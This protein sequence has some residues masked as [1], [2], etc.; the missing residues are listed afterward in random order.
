VQVTSQHGRQARRLRSAT[1]APPAART[2]TTT[3]GATQPGRPVPPWAALRTGS[4]PV[5]ADGVGSDAVGPDG[6]TLAATFGEDVRAA[7]AL[8]D[9]LGEALGEV[10]G[11]TPADV[12]GDDVP[13]TLGLAAADALPAE[14]LPIGA[15]DGRGFVVLVVEEP[16]GAGWLTGAAGVLAAVGADTP[17]NDLPLPLCQAQ[18]TAP[19]SGT[20]SAVT[21]RL[22]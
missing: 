3:V 15:F 5:T 11:A 1:T 7:A 16:A 20:E 13:L 10:L 18:A 2:S 12:L 9:A 21:P 4:A 6:V 14:T 22:E 19:P 8:A 17:G